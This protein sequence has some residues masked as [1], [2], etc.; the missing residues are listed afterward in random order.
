MA[1]WVDVL[2]VILLAVAAGAVLW[3]MR[4][5]AIYRRVGVGLQ[6]LKE[7]KWPGPLRSNPDDI[8]PVLTAFD[9]LANQLRQNE[10]TA[11]PRDNVDLGPVLGQLCEALRP[12]L[13]AIHGYV[14]ILERELGQTAS[15]MERDC[16]VSL[17]AH[18]HGLLRLIE[19]STD[20]SEL[21]RGLSLLPQELTSRQASP[22]PAALLV[23]EEGPWTRDLADALRGEGY[24]VAPASSVESAVVIAQAIA[25]RAI[26]VNVSLADGQGW[27]AI[28]QLARTPGTAGAR[29]V[30]YARESADQ[31]G[32]YWA[33][34]DLWV[35]PDER[36]ATLF[37]GGWIGQADGVRFSLHGAS[38]VALE[39]A[40]VLADAGMA[41]V[42]DAPE[43]ALAIDPCVT[44]LVLRMTPEEPEGIELD[45][46]LILPESTALREG[47]TLTEAFKESA[48]FR[49][50][51]DEELRARIVKRLCDSLG[52]SAGKVAANA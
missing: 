35:W 20:A 50:Y 32:R 6:A 48:W 21:R 4:Q 39:I 8:E 7:G 44:L 25:P 11:G 26:L 34:G 28:A 24:R 47:G 43:P 38:Q 33:P 10:T 22:A 45:Q 27:A 49:T 40:R 30:L 15:P 29:Y 12:P 52:A 19:G 42:I 14:L 51:P 9:E 1:G 16:L 23:D 17:R 31:A 3:G 37:A 13:T 36:A 2:N 46:I 41:V 18:A 5:R